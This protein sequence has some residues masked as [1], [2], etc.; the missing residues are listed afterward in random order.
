[1]KNPLAMMCAGFAIGA[2]LTALATSAAQRTV[3][4]IGPA[5]DLDDPTN[6]G[7]WTVNRT[8]VVVDDAERL[9]SGVDART[10]AWSSKTI[11]ELEARDFTLMESLGC[12]LDTGRTG[13]LIV[14]W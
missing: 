13:C 1:M 2:T 5:Q 10:V 11:S 3:V 14:V 6:G 12:N 7:F 8:S 4:D 9:T